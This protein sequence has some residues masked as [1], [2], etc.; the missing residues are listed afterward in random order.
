M[1]QKMIV[2]SLDSSLEKKIKKLMMATDS[3][4]SPNPVNNNLLGAKCPLSIEINTA[5]RVI[6]IAP[7]NAPMDGR[8][9]EVIVGGIMK[10]T[11]LAPKE[12]PLAV[13]KI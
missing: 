11:K 13:P 12:A 5:S 3:E 4:E 8:A 10:Y 1:L 6:N 2:L 9:M 7:T